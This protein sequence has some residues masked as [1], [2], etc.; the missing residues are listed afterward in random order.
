MRLS[1]DE[2]LVIHQ[3][4]IE[5]FRLSVMIYWKYLYLERMQ[6][7]GR[8]RNRTIIPK[9]KQKYPKTFSVAHYEYIEFS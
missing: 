1:R 6:N 5:V 4:L 3:H 7:R 9:E 8:L 2:A